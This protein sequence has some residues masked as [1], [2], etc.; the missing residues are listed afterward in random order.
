MKNEKERTEK[1]PGSWIFKKIGVLIERE[2]IKE[3]IENY[4]RN[5]QENFSDLNSTEYPAQWIKINPIPAHQCKIS[6]KISRTLKG[7][8][9]GLT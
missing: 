4:Q 3:W 1:C 6:K 5:N 2:E 9:T 7:V 8:K